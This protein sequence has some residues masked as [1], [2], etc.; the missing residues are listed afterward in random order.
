MNDFDNTRFSTPSI[1]FSV[2]HFFETRPRN[3]AFNEL[4]A[5]FIERQT[6][7]LELISNCSDEEQKEQYNKEIKS[8]VDIIEKIK[9]YIDFFI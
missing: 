8:I 3:E 6:E 9:F 5:V 1:E 7:L 4:I 2:K